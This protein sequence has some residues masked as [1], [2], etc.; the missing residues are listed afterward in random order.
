MKYF[1]GANTSCLSGLMVTSQ[2][3]ERARL[4]RQGADLFLSFNDFRS[5]H[6]NTNHAL[7][8]YKESS[9]TPLHA[10]CR[11]LFPPPLALAIESNVS[12]VLMYPSQGRSPQSLPQAVS[13]P[14]PPSLVY[15]QERGDV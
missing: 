5:P 9:P 13:H 12:P 14:R 4:D 15:R 8:P 6:L 1:I 7:Y 2:A 10:T 11:G 3:Q